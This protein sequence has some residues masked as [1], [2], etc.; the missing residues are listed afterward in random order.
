LAAIF[1]LSFATHP[2]KNACAVA[3]VARGLV[4]VA[5][6]V[7]GGGGVVDAIARVVVGA[8]VVVVAV[9]T[10][11]AVVAEGRVKALFAPPLESPQP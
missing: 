10:A 6:A 11:G 1:A 9:V 8:L 7:V 2:S 4:V 5:P 3:S